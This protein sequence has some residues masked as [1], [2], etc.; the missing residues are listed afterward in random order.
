MCVQ[1]RKEKRKVRVSNYTKTNVRVFQH[2]VH[3][4]SCQFV[5]T[6]RANAGISWVW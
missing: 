6:N 2:A 1:K 3:D 5:T 4:G